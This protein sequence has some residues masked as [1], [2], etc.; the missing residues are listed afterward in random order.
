[1]NLLKKFVV[2]VACIFAFGA[3]NATVITIEQ[4]IDPDPDYKVTL[5]TPASMVFDLNA[6]LAAYGVT[7]MD[8]LSATLDVFL[9]DPYSGQERYAISVGG[10]LQTVT[11]TGMN[12]VPNGMS[13]LHVPIPLVAA[14]ADLQAD[15]ILNV[16]IALASTS[17]DFDFM[18]ARLS[19]T[20]NEPV[21]EVPEPVSAALLGLGLAGVYAARRR[22]VNVRAA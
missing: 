2:A 3:A 16:G 6:L 1:M 11:G 4:E 9:I 12:Q 22:R 19:A 20:F 14:L 13:P 5:T 18:R 10:G 17:G 8:I 15:G 7:S 21:G